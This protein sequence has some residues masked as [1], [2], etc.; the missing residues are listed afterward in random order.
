MK[1]IVKVMAVVM[2]AIFMIQATCGKPK[3]VTITPYE[4]IEIEDWVYYHNMSIAYDGSQYITMNG[5][6]DD[7]CIINT[8]E[9]DGEWLYDFDLGIDGRTIFY[10]AKKSRLLGKLYGTGLYELKLNEDQANLLYTDVFEYDNSSVAFA[11]DG[12][13]AYELTETGYIRFINLNN[14]KF[15]K[16]IK[17][18][19]YTD[20]H[21]FATS[22]AASDKYFFI[23]G[24]LGS[25]IVVLDLK[26]R[27][28]TSFELPRSGLS[29]S[30]S[31]CNNM[32]WIAEDADGADEGYTGYWYGYSLNIQ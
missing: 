11:P 12:K 26:G 29:F 21:G 31:Y 1:D 7:Y 32:L 8:Y 13:Y 9:D 16:Q 27:Y 18:T 20:E 6:N 3:P 2:I 5:G 23:W 14:G 28:V 19:T 30:L 17:I 25:E 22:M 4:E 15:E 10:D 24:A